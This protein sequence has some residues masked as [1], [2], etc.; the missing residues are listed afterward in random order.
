MTRTP[1]SGEA[2]IG[3]PVRH[4]PPYPRAGSSVLDAPR[5]AGTDRDHPPALPVAGMDGNRTHLGRLSTAPQTVLKT[6]EGT[7]PRTSPR[8]LA[9][10]RPPRAH[11]YGRLD[12]SAAHVGLDPRA[13]GS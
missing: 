12:V 9:Y 10:R 3:L 1:G 8:R 2:E 13:S 7:S 11:S 4:G 6:A 5:V